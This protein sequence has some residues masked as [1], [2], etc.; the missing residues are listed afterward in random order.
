MLES[1]GF[2]YG[3]QG[4]YDLAIET[5][6]QALEIKPTSAAYTNKGVA[7][8]KQG[9]S[10]EAEQNFKRAVELDDKDA[11]AW[12]N[13]GSYYAERNQS[14][15]AKPALEKSLGLSPKNL[16]ALWNLGGIY[17]NSG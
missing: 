13:L 1:L 2:A 15:K 17:F 9:K 12:S 4:N 16:D 6:N 5:L 11:M 10:V 7:F 8:L 14:S 3:V